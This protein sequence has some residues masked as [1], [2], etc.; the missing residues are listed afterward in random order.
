[1]RHLLLLCFLLA[2]TTVSAAE[3]FAAER[4]AWNQQ[5]APFRIIDDVYYVG[6]ADLAVYLIVTPRGDILLDGG[7]P[8]SADLVERNIAALGFQVSDIKILLNSHA[9]FDHAGGLAQIK[10]DSGATLYASRADTPILEQG[11]IEFGPSQIV[12]FPP[13]VV[14]R[15]VSDGQQIEL[16]ETVLTAHLTPGHTPGCTTWTMPVVE[17]NR[18]HNVVFYCSTTVAGNPLVGNAAQPQIV[19]QYRGSFAKLKTLTA[20]VF[21]APHASMFNPQKKLAA[22]KPGAPNPFV[23]KKE[24]QAF[25]AASERDFE[26]E[27]ARQKAAAP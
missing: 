18:H 11:Y 20:D 6:T 21:L 25:V 19:S 4:A 17:D 1:M 15:G 27:L 10:R 9:H 8:E 23:D 26:T 12:H 5:M 3:P 14:D 2:A 24:F 13:A 16:G 7:L 22:R